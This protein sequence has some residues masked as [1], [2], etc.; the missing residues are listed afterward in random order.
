MWALPNQGG[1]APPPGA[2]LASLFTAYSGS[3]PAALLP[4]GLPNPPNA[5]FE[6]REFGPAAAAMPPPRRV[7]PPRLGLADRRSRSLR[8]PSPPAPPR[9]R[10]GLREL[11]LGDFWT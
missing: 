5:F 4:Q 10:S 9:A 7:P 2:T 1:R 3:G 11:E 6:S 8:S